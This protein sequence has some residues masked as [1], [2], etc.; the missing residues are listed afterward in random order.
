MQFLCGCPAVA[1]VKRPPSFFFKLEALKP[2]GLNDLKAKGTEWCV[3]ES[4][5]YLAF[6]L[7]TTSSATT[8]AIIKVDAK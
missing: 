7:V 2:T 1:S 3:V 8:A 5:T 4:S 6:F